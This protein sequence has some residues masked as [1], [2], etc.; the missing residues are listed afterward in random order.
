M[1]RR[2]TFLGVVRFTDRVLVAGYSPSEAD[3]S[4]IIKEVGPLFD[5]LCIK[6]FACCDT[7]R[8]NAERREHRRLKLANG[9]A[10]RA[11]GA[12]LC[13]VRRPLLNP[14]VRNAFITMLSRGVEDLR[15]LHQLTDDVCVVVC[16]DAGSRGS[17]FQLVRVGRDREP[18]LRL[19]DRPSESIAGYMGII[20]CY[21]PRSPVAAKVARPYVARVF[22]CCCICKT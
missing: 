2:I 21:S 4:L 15:C 7:K 8:K 9:S 1:S 14:L 18:S 17:R 5:V 20:R 6:R 13:S 10:A 3:D 16:P 11:R 19:N 22:G 12:L